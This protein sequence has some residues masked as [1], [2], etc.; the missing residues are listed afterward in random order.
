MVVLAKS[1][2]FTKLRVLH[3]RRCIV[4]VRVQDIGLNGALLRCRLSMRGSHNKGSKEGV[5]L[6]R[7]ILTKDIE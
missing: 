2:T 5:L 3:L 7:I 4:S 6:E 1:F